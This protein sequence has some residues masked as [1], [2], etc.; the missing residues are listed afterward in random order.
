MFFMLSK[1][2]GLLAV[3]SNALSMIGLAGLLLLRS[4]YAGLGRWL[5]GLSALLLAGCGFLPIGAALSVPLD[6]RFPPWNPVHDAPTGIIILI[7]GAAA[8]PELAHEYPEAQFV[9]VGGNPSLFVNAL[10]ESDSIG[11]VLENCGVSRERIAYERRSRNTIENAVFAKDV[12]QPKPS[13]RWLL[14]TSRLH[15]ARAV[16]TFRRVGFPVE[17]Y[18]VVEDRSWI[19]GS[20]ASGLVAMDNAMHEWIGLLVYWMTGHIDE[21]LP[22]PHSSQ[23][24]T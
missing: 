16:G 9:V 24:R 17:T 14:V 4:Q 7:G 20:L 23:T 19:T 15:M 11:R 8:A 2:I 12:A 6:D 3:P 21:L 22:G 10:P 18:P 1:A 5:L 13:D